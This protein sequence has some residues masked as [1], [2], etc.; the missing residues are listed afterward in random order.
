MFSITEF[1]ES[2]GHAFSYSKVIVDCM[3]QRVGTITFPFVP[4]IPR[5]KQT[6]EDAGLFSPQESKV[7]DDTNMLI[8][9]FYGE[10]KI[11]SVLAAE[12]EL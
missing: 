2:T 1:P 6:K 12:K 9:L 11:H 8:C 5:L 7:P 10:Y 3:K 4:V